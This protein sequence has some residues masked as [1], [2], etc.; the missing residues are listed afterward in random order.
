MEL[1]RALAY[2]LQRLEAAGV[3][4]KTAIV[5]VGD[6]F[7]YGLGGSGTKELTGRG[8]DKFSKQKSTLIF[9]VGGME[10][11]IVVDEYC[12]NVDIL[13]TILNLWD[14]E[15]DSRLLAG[16]DVLPDGLHMA[17]LM[18]KS[19]LN[20]HIRFDSATGKATYRTEEA[21]LPEDYRDVLIRIV[22]TKFQ[23]SSDILNSAYYNFIFGKESV[24]VDNENRTVKQTAAPG[25]PGRRF[26][27]CGWI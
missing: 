13:P 2:L 21:Q 1:D 8:I 5:L 15:Y 12:C 11:N 22:K 4:D 20:E 25:N 27:G 23:I 9:W 24:I 14:F 17:V 10:E 3:A 6:H 19:F 26:S 16:T 18:D 7:P